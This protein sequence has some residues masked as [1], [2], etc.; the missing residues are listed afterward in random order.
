MRQN[1]GRVKKSSVM[2]NVWCKHWV[3]LWGISNATPTPNAAPLR[4]ASVVIC[5]IFR[6]RGWVKTWRDWS[7]LAD[8]R[9]QSACWQLLSWQQQ[10]RALCW[11][12]DY[13][14]DATASLPFIRAAQAGI[15]LT[16]NCNVLVHSLSLLR[17]AGV[18]LW[19]PS[20]CLSV[21]SFVSRITFKSYWWI[22]MKFGEYWGLDYGPKSWLVLELIW[23]IPYNGC[24]KFTSWQDGTKFPVTPLLSL[25]FLNCKY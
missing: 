18:L 6:L 19:P 3:K 5:I 8:W 11:R 10:V 17:S 21:C 16:M 24:R 14:I 22:V 12:I 25:S 13:V 15:R 1:R 23:N 9:A 7:Q 20:V 4:H 2:M